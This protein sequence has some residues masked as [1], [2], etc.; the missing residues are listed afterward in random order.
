MAEG[1]RTAKRGVWNRVV[2]ESRQMRV[3]ATAAE[4]ALWQRLRNR[5]LGVRFRRQHTIDRF[6]VDFCC[7]EAKLVIEV[8]GPI[9][10]GR[11]EEDSIREA[12]LQQLGFT[13]LRFSNDQVLV[14]PQVVIE[15]I[16]R[17]LRTASFAQN[18]QSDAP[19]PLGEGD[20]G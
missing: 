4:D 8:D 14:H 6:I 10:D 5:A 16:R 18:V 9:H 19:S 1:W 20:G 12:H 11:Q 2:S 7:L 13:V 15:R 17:V 3:Q